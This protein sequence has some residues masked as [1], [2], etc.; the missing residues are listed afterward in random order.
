MKK[1]VLAAVA[2]IAILSVQAQSAKVVSARNYLNEFEKSND[3]D[4]LNKAKEAIDLASQNPD[5]KD[6]AKTQVYRGQIYLTYFEKN[7]RTETE[8]LNT[9]ITDPKKRE[10]TG[11]QNTP[12]DMLDI[13]YQAFTQAKSLDAKGNYGTEISNGVNKVAFYYNN[14]AAYDY[15]GKR[16]AESLTSF[17][18]AY[19]MGGK[20]DTNLLYNCALTAD[21]SGNYDKAK[22]YYGQMIEKKQGRANTYSSLVN[23]HLNAK[24]TVGGMAVLKKGRTEYPNDINLLISE[25]NFYLKANKSAEALENLNQAIQTKPTE[26]N[27]YLVRGNLH[28]N[29]GNPK[30]ESGKD[31]EKPKD[32]EDRLK[33]AEADYKKAIE[34]KP[35]YF[36]AL[37]NLGV[38]YNNHGVAI[39]KYADKITD[40]AKYAAENAK[41]TDEFNKAMPILEKAL[42]VKPKDRDTMKALKQIYARLQQLDKLK[43]I[44]AQL[45]N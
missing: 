39:A 8:K 9:T 37:Y 16:F 17:E 2:S 11:Y 20:K 45:A 30:D 43:E 35:D 18:K 22:L 31:L 25:T 34:L 14:K 19:E 28:D 24:D 3:I 27:L 1:L 36:D 26:A 38:L 40:N 42:Q 7:L 33:M 10:M 41:A 5:T 32:Y 13:A 12:V 6:N 21:R 23:V 44:N 15:N 4:Y 29:L